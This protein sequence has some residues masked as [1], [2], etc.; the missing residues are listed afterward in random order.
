MNNAM[1]RQKDISEAESADRGKSNVALRELTE[2]ELGEVA[3]GA[4]WYKGWF[5]EDGVWYQGWFL[6]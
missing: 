6:A 2:K 3:G 5:K 1:M 4:R